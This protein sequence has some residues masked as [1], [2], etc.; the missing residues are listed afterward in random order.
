M[1][2]A[3]T[4]KWKIL[5]Y[6]LLG[7]ASITLFANAWTVFGSNKYMEKMRPWKSNMPIA[8][9]EIALDICK[10]NVH[11]RVHNISP[12]DHALSLKK[13]SVKLGPLSNGMA[14]V[15]CMSLC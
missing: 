10:P 7:V 8:S 5:R 3:V 6:I 13:L 11:Y 1:F 9:R 14:F 4:N 2:I 15:R 12:L